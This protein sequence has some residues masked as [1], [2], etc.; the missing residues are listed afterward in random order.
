MEG[1][2]IIRRRKLLCRYVLCR[3]TYLHQ[4]LCHQCGLRF[5]CLVHPYIIC[6]LYSP[7]ISTLSFEEDGHVKIEVDWFC[8][9]YF[10]RT[11]ILTIPY[12]ID[13]VSHPERTELLETVDLDCQHWSEI[14]EIRQDLLRKR[15]LAFSSLCVAHFVAC[16]PGRT[17]QA[18]LLDVV[19]TKLF[20]FR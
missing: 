7:V 13:V 19:A 4:D 15:L 10:E 12:G 1:D 16:H 11:I 8:A 20:C 5:S 18:C 6:S 14:R 2:G 17:I 9:A 3:I